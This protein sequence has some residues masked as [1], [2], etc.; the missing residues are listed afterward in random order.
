MK[1]KIDKKKEAEKQVNPEFDRDDYSYRDK[2]IFKTIEQ[3]P[4]LTIKEVRTSKKD[5]YEPQ[6]LYKNKA[7]MQCAHS[8]YAFFSA[9]L[10][11]K[12]RQIIRVIDGESALQVYEWIKNR[13]KTIDKEIKVVDKKVK[14]KTKQKSEKTKESESIEN[15]EERVE[16]LSPKSNAIH[17]SNPTPEI[18]SW[19]E[20]SNY[21]F[22]DEH[23]LKVKM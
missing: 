5:E 16:N 9:Y 14:Q 10:F 2:W 21:Q 4:E 15:L 3:I 19:A 6:L 13:V 7:I 18:L 17:I 12:E 23:T 22:M 1:E 11:D 20:S 8:K